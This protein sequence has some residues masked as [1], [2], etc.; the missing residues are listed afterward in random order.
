MSSPWR[1]PP[2]ARAYSEQMSAR[3]TV[4][5]AALVAAVLLTACGGDGYDSS[6]ATTSAADTSAPTTDAVTTDAPT[7]APSTAPPTTLPPTLDLDTLPGLLAVE[8][9]SCAPEPY[10]PRDVVENT[11]VCTLK[12]NGTD[13]KVVSQPGEDPFGLAFARDGNHLWYGDPYTQFGYVIDLTTGEH[14]ERQRYEPTRSGVSPDGSLFLYVSSYTYVLTIAPSD[15]STLP[16]GSVSRAVSDDTHVSNWGEA[17][18][19]PDG[20]R[21][22]Y[23]STNDGSGGDL[24]CAEVWIGS[25]DGT[26]PVK[27]TDFASAPEGAAACAQSVRWSPTDDRILL[28][29]VGKPIFVVDNLFVINADG[30]DLTELTTGIPNP[31]PSLAEVA[32]AGSSY[33]GDWSPDGKYIA[34]IFGNDDASGYH[35]AV[36]NA[37]GSQVTP[38]AAAP[39]GITSSL[40]SIRWSLG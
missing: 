30:S 32:I 31:D 3:P 7:T 29:L 35:L 9:L 21:F 37:D 34:F 19:A 26:P 20:I 11:V 4:R 39:L 22:A 16:D 40:A 13:T 1:L 12:P 28:H 23:L 36:M 5:S 14:R 2:T 25:I 27:I 15:G 17:S 18:W 6:T 38:I 8:A 10:P 24:E 33:A